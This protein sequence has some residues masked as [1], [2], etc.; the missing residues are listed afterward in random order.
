MNYRS[1][2]RVLCKFFYNIIIYIYRFIIYREKYGSIMKDDDDDI[3]YK[4]KG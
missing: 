3:L 2:I 1:T 4:G